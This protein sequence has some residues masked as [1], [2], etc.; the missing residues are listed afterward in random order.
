MYYHAIVHLLQHTIP[1][2]ERDNNERND[3]AAGE[4]REVAGD[5]VI[6]DIFGELLDPGT[7]DRRSQTATAAVRTVS[8]RNVVH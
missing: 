3:Q 4:R 5:D 1:G 7:A 2:K 8:A 6:R